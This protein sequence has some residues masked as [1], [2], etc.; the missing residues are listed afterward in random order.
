M[1]QAKPFALIIT[2]S[3]IK[4]AFLRKFLSKEYQ[5]MT[6]QN[7]Y[8]IVGKLQSLPLSLIIFDAKI[9]D[10]NPIELCRLIR[11][12][13]EYR[14]IPLLIIT[15]SLKKK[16]YQELVSA[17]ASDLLSDPLDEEE[18]N[19][20]LAVNAK[21]SQSSKKIDFLQKSFAS[22][23]PRA[24]TS[25]QRHFLASE[26]IL[27]QIADSLREKKDF[28][29]IIAQVDQLSEE[30]L[31]ASPLFIEEINA[32][33]I[34][35]WKSLLRPQDILVPMG[36]GKY[37]ILLPKTSQK[38]GEYIA[39]I[40]RDEVKNVEC[41]TRQ[42]PFSLTISIGLITESQAKNEE[43][44]Y[45]HLDRLIKL[46]LSCLEKAKKTGNRIVTQK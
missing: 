37:I 40:I 21:I 45:Q 13:E 26:N 22:K 24:S 7:E 25:F 4:S 6:C 41:K 16:W 1:N 38:A 23:K 17:G 42:G 9:P 43:S 2:R 12:Y 30:S 33:I 20:R 10:I 18:I 8:E 44:T 29:L 36:N 31:A 15:T 5:V 11:S 28:S 46:A 32:H 39:E 34:S 14:D 35:L 19:K 3:A 27:K